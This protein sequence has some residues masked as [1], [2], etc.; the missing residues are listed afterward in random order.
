[1]YAGFLALQVVT[2]VDLAFH[3]LWALATGMAASAVATTV[4]ISL[5]LRHQH[6]AADSTARSA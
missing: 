1:M 5:A 4:I 3:Q 6:L 2:G